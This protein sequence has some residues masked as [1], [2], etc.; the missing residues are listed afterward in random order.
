MRIR[1]GR[2][3]PS[4]CERH[5]AP[6]ITA[7]KVDRGRCTFLT[8][9][10]KPTPFERTASELEMDGT[11]RIPEAAFATHREFYEAR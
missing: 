1:R 8:T 5:L 11:G 6:R 2:Y 7:K 10:I 3:W 9:S 4:D